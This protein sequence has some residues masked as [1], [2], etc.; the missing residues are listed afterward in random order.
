[1][2]YYKIMDNTRV[3]GAGTSESMRRFQAKHSIL[4]ICAEDEAQYMQYGD[5]L[6][7]AEWMLRK[8]ASVD[9]MD[10][11]I[12]VIEET[13]YD[14][15]M[16]IL[17]AGEEYIEEPVVEPAE[18]GPSEPETPGNN[19][20]ERPMTIQQMR[21]KLAEIE[22]KQKS[23]IAKENIPKGKFFILHDDIYLATSPIVKGTEIKPGY[24]CKKKSLDAISSREGAHA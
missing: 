12:I 11:Q 15:I 14:E 24:N 10:A 13:E 6:Y 17:G 21:E 22:E 8:S 7:H 2:N 18:E 19:E 20:P 9:S 16:D 4:M 5:M 3:I 1:M 23:M